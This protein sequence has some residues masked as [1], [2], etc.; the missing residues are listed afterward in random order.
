VSVDVLGPSGSPQVEAEVD[1]VEAAL[2]GERLLQGGVEQRPSPHRSVADLQLVDHRFAADWT[3]LRDCW[4]GCRGFVALQGL[5]LVGVS[6]S[7]RRSEAAFS[8]FLGEVEPRLR[9]ALVAAYGPVDGR[10]ATVDALS[11]AWEHWDRLGDIANPA[12]YLFRVGQSAV[13]RFGSRPLPVDV[14]RA[15]AAWMPELSPELLPALGRLSTQQRTIVV[16]VHAYGWSQAD[17]ASLLDINPSTVR[18]HLS[19]GLARLRDELEVG[20]DD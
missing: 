6:L 11:W 19:R 7:S 20:D 14:L 9:Q 1:H 4:F 5:T 12:G 18:E 10:E 13:R 15:S 3:E 17:V 8:V 2:R 16:L